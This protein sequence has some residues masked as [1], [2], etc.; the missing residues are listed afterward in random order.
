MKDETVAYKAVVKFCEIS[1]N[2]YFYEILQ[3]SENNVYEYVSPNQIV[4][5]G[6]VDEIFSEMS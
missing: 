3:Q 2:S 6:S 4:C 1:M 5:R